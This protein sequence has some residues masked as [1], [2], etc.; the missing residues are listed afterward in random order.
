MTYRWAR[1]EAQVTFKALVDGEW[2]ILTGGRLGAGDA[3]YGP[4]GE[5]V[6]RMVLTPGRRPTLITTVAALDRAFAD[7][8]RLF[9]VYDP[10]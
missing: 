6:A 8:H 3:F 7:L 9:V 4:D 10:D 5:I 1:D 2:R